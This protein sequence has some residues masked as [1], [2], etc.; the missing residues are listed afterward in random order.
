MKDR[1]N[2]HGNAICLSRYKEIKP[3]IFS[4]ITTLATNV[5]NRF[6]RINWEIKNNLI[7]SHVDSDS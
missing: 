4:A 3:N 2:N 1:Q 5:S 7:H 6:L